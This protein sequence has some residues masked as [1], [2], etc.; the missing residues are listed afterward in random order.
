[1]EAGLNARHFK[2]EC[3]HLKLCF[4]LLCHNTHHNPTLNAFGYTPRSGISQSQGSSIYNVLRK[5]HGPL[6]RGS[7]LLS[8][9]S[10]I[11]IRFNLG[12]GITFFK[13][14]D[15]P[16]SGWSLLPWKACSWLSK[17]LPFWPSPHLCLKSNVSEIPRCTHTPRC[18][19]KYPHCSPWTV[20]ISTGRLS[21]ISQPGGPSPTTEALQSTELAEGKRR[22]REG[23]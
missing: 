8:K 11:K 5:C 20:T 6:L 13:E 9:T 15:G 2:T 10:F 19:L 18:L 22:Q 1:M 21:W 17:A 3:R 16:L 14:A 12:T 23:L 4:N 7:E